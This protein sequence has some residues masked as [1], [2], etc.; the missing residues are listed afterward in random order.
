MI[1]TP[2]SRYT[3]PVLVLVQA[4]SRLREAARQWGIPG[5]NQAEEGKGTFTAD[6]KKTSK[7]DTTHATLYPTLTG[8]RLGRQKSTASGHSPPVTGTTHDVPP[9]VILAII[10]SER[11]AV[12]S[13]VEGTSSRHRGVHPNVEAFEHPVIIPESAI[14]QRGKIET[15][16]TN[17]S[18]GRDIDTAVFANTGRY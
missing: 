15:R 9:L 5:W 14:H 11:A 4:T 3:A 18:L 10:E 7:W 16:L 8:V 13:G 6:D 12:A 1:C 2:S 17:A